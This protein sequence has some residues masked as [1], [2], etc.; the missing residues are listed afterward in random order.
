MTDLTEFFGKEGVVLDKNF[1]FT[2]TS[3]SNADLISEMQSHGLLVD[4]LDTSGALVRV[5]VSAGQNHRP[6]K[7][8]EKSG[9]YV[10]NQLDQH[11]VC[12]Y[13]N[14]R[15]SFE[16]KFTSYNPNKMSAEQKRDLQQKLDEAQKKREESKK[17]QHEQVSIYAKEKYENA[18]EVAEHKYLTNKKVKNYGLKTINGNLLIA[19][20]SITKNDKGILVSDIKSLQYIYPN[21][22]KKFAG[23]GEVK[24]NIFLIN[25]EPNDLKNIDNLYIVEGYATGASIASLG[26]PVCVVFSANFCLSALTRL[27]S[28]G[29]NTR[30]V[31]CLDNDESGVGQKCANEVAT[32]VSNSIVRL[33]S[34]IG[35]FN[36]LYLQQG[37]EQVE[38]ELLES[39]F[40]IRQYAIRNLVEAP[41]PIE[42]LVDSFIPLAKPGIIAA[43]GGVGKS[44]SMIQLALG[45]AT[46]GNWWGKP[47]MQKGSSVIFAAEDDL[48]EVH[49]RIEALDPNGERLKSQYDVYVFP[50]PEQKEPMIL[51]REEG[52]TS[53]AQELVEELKTIPNLKFVCFDP[54]Q[55]FTT[56]NISSSNEVGQLW[57]SYCANISARLGVTTLTVHHLSKS[58]LTNDSDDALSHRAEIRGASSITDSVR[59]AIA[60][61]LADK[62]TC[63]KICIEQGIE[64]DRM[65]VVK[66]SLV[67]SNSGN[68]D[69]GVKTLIRK[70]AVLEILEKNK[71]FDWD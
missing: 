10:Y 46:G 24:G 32:A 25:C 68:V 60:M 28:M 43:V 47:I 23:G 65:S 7:A 54:L 70:G 37:I 9:Y 51:L 13:G 16:G 44:L 39:K 50:I 30:F 5:P 29:I 67:K 8:G 18:K 48:N 34:I 35:D 71:S 19:V 58:A 45:V 63:E 1:A 36:D 6:D 4:Y 61:W 42:W 41:K 33:P 38:L 2:N 27:R 12:V 56:G 17:I 22:D 49:R 62:D 31:L 69:Y 20:Y 11:F 66:A 59:F 55:A 26:L 40:N 52:V 57:G 3:K 53:Q 15:T 21:G 64:V 14:W